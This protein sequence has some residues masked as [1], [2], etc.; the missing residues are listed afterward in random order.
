MSSKPTE[1]S[2]KVQGSNTTWLVRRLPSEH[3]EIVTYIVHL[4]PERTCRFA[5]MP[6]CLRLRPSRFL[7]LWGCIWCW[8]WLWFGSSVLPLSVVV[9]VST[10]LILR[11]PL[12]L[13][14]PLLLVSLS[15]LMPLPFLPLLLPAFSRLGLCFRW[16]PRARFRRL[17]LWWGPMIAARTMWRLLTA[18]LLLFLRLVCAIKGRP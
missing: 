14:F 12:L 5:R 8:L 9:I 6:P 1:C 4:Q 7:W 17:C 16:R 13:L 18:A 15:F 10:A 2:V 3:H 11:V